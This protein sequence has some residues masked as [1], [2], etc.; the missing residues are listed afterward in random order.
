MRFS[1]H[2]LEVLKRKRNE[3]EELRKEVLKKIEKILQGLSKKSYLKKLLFLAP[4]Q[5]LMDLLKNRILI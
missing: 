3:N 2:I 1:T 5:N 4:S